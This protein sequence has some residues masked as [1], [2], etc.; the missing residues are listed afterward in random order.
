[1]LATDQQIC[2]ARLVCSTR[3]PAWFACVRCLRAA[4]V[5]RAGAGAPGGAS[6]ASALLPHAARAQLAHALAQRD[7]P[8]ALRALH[9]QFDH[10]QVRA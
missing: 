2:Q 5:V 9:A 7:F 1:M 6:A 3:R 10:A 8:G 4:D